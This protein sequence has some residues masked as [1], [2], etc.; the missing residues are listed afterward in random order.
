MVTESRQA[1]NSRAMTCIRYDRWRLAFLLIFE[2]VYLLL[3]ASYI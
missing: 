2:V 1:L 3:I